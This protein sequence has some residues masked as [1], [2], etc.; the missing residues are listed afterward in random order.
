MLETGRG[1]ENEIAMNLTEVGCRMCVDR[2]GTGKRMVAGFGVSGGEA[3]LSAAGI[4]INTYIFIYPT[5]WVITLR[6]FSPGLDHC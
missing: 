3:A 2:T 1:C 5:F 6:R 4:L